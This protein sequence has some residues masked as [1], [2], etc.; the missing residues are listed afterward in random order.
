MALSNTYWPATQLV[1]ASLIGLLNGDVVTNLIVFVANAGSGA[2]PTRIELGLYD[3]SDNRL[4][5]TG[6]IASDAQ[7]TTNS[8]YGVFAL[9]APFTITADAGYYVAFLTVGAF[10][11][12]NP[13]ILKAGADTAGLGKAIG[14][15]HRAC[16]QQ[17]GQASLPAT[18]TE[19]ANDDYLWVATS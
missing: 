13:K 6:N 14:S 16:W 1:I 15:N 18:A 4:A 10:G 17:S 12:S 2:V 5:T 7:W 3:L 8:I 11:T 19:A 9:S